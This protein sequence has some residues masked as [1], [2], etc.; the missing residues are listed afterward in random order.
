LKIEEPALRKTVLDYH[1]RARD[2]WQGILDKA[3]AE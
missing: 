1:R 3:T 2:F